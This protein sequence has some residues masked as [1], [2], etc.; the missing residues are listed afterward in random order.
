M[1]RQTA[2]RV[3]RKAILNYRQARILAWEDESNVIHQTQGQEALEQV[4]GALC[5]FRRK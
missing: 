5:I 4:K 3:V 2:F 1:K